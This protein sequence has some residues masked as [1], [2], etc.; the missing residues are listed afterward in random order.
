MAKVT[1]RSEKEAAVN[2]LRHL[3][4][5]VRRLRRSGPGASVGQPIVLH[6]DEEDDEEESLASDS[7]VEEE[8]PLAEKPLFNRSRIPNPLSLIYTVSRFS[9]VYGE[10]PSKDAAEGDGVRRSILQAACEQMVSNHDYWTKEG[11]HYYLPQFFDIQEDK[12][13]QDQWEAYGILIATS[14]ICIT[15]L[16]ASPF[17]IMALMAPDGDQQLRLTKETIAIFNKPAATTLSPWL[18][19]GPTDDIPTNPNNPVVK[20]LAEFDYQPGTIGRLRDTPKKHWAL[21]STFLCRILLKCANPWVNAEF[22]A[23]RKGFNLV[24]KNKD[25]QKLTFVK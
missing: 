14:L 17:L 10:Y 3:L 13:R 8:I 1:G 21:M 9:V 22:K 18:D 6:S 15:S 20:F 23:L 12:R 5:L 7:D 11:R 24:M 4:S 2:L 25:G 16:P 19:L